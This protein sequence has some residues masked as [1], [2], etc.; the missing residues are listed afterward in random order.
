M[1][2]KK[3][4]LKFTLAIVFLL[5]F[6]TFACKNDIHEPFVDD[7]YLI[8]LDS[9]SYTTWKITATNKNKLSYIANDFQVSHIIFIDSICVDK[10]YSDKP[11]SIK[12]KDFKAL[13]SKCL[14]L[15]PN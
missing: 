8:Q 4:I 14:N 5:L 6:S 13:D 10:N 2:L 11:K 3:N 15:K 12:R 7:V 1:I 9:T